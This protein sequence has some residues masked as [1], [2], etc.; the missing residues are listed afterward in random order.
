M[1]PSE[2]FGGGDRELFEDCDATPDELFSLRVESI[3]AKTK[4]REN[5]KPN[6]LFRG[7]LL[8]YF[9]DLKTFGHLSTA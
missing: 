5:S 4:I 6:F 2:D 9:G 3:A 8:A 7:T 1:L